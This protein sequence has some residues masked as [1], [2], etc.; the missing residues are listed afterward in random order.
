MPVNQPPAF[1]ERKTTATH[2]SDT[3]KA[4]RFYQ[5]RET[6]KV[7]KKLEVEHHQEIP[8]WLGLLGFGYLLSV[9]WAPVMATVM[10][11]GSQFSPGNHLAFLGLIYHP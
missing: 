10:P 9:V 1:N 4:L 2:F 11:L 7:E 6:L 3:I 5:N 8:D